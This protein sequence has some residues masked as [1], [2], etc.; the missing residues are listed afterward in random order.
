[1]FIGVYNDKLEF[2]MMN[3][4]LKLFY[5]TVSRKPWINKGSKIRISQF[6]K[7]VIVVTLT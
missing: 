7:T 3:R 6:S 1:M 4:T 5:K 2:R